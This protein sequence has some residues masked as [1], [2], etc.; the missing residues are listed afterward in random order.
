MIAPVEL[1]QISLV[2]LLPS[3]PLSPRIDQMVQVTPS[4]VWLNLGAKLAVVDL[5]VPSVVTCWEE[6]RND[7]TA[8][9][10]HEG[11]VWVAT[12]QG[13][14][15]AFDAAS[16]APQASISSQANFLSICGVLKHEIWVGDRM[17]QLHRYQTSPLLQ[18]I[19]TV[20]LHTGAITALKY[21]RHY[22]F[23]SSWDETLTIINP[24]L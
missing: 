13:D 15:L 16:R 11:Q 20:P 8:I 23:S 24:S 22:V 18:L 12:I 9:A 4:C 14:L 19:E 5:T 6:E 3:I 21:D 17:G 7:I 1:S 10:H 2:N